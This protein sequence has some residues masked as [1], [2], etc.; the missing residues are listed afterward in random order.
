MPVLW[1][2]ATMV[3]VTQRPNTTRKHNNIST[4]KL[5]LKQ[6]RGRP[7]N[8][9]LLLFCHHNTTLPTCVFTCSVWTFPLYL[10]FPLFFLL[11][12]LFFFF[13]FFFF[14]F[15]LL[16][17]GVSLW[18]CPQPICLPWGFS[19]SSCSM[20]TRCHKWVRQTKRETDLPKATHPPTLLRSC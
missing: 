20:S 1:K 14:N 6:P 4:S 18:I 10:F 11:L 5:N 12:L 9:G 17:A 2:T 13:F 16:V 3:H 8:G 15:F 7:K 19:V